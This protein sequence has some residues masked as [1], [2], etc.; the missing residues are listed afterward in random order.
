MDA[1]LTLIGASLF[2]RLYASLCA[3]VCVP[4]LPD[5]S[6]CVE[7]ILP[8]GAWEN[9]SLEREG[10]V[11]RGIERGEVVVEDVAPEE[12]VTTEESG[13]E[14]QRVAALRFGQGDARPACVV[15]LPED[16]RAKPA[17][18]APEKDEL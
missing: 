6:M 5:A 9:C 14:Q 15:V 3:S 18:G 2:G 13:L 1:F 8:E 17:G 11:E 16:I 10:P 4:P 7:I 12:L